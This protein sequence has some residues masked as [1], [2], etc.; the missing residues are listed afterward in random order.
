[1]SAYI[2]SPIHIAT[3]A[4]IIKTQCHLIG[5]KISETDI[6]VKLAVE[7]FNSV[8]FRYGPEGR[9]KYA[10]LLGVIAGELAKAGWDESHVVSCNVDDRLPGLAEGEFCLISVCLQGSCT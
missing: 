9:A 4:H 8:A 10:L 7:N 1:M 3:C 6:R 2:C 5:D